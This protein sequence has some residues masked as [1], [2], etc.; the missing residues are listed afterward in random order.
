MDIKYTKLTVKCLFRAAGV[1]TTESRVWGQEEDGR[2][3]EARSGG[4]RETE[5]RDTRNGG[6]RQREGW[7][8]KVPLICPC[9]TKYRISA[10][11][12][13]TESVD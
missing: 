5:S 3:S 1:T 12:L 13:S 6:W 9:V 7:K 8:E 4:G 2:T 10:T 11:Q